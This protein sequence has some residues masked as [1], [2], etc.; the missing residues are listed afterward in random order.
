MKLVSRWWPPRGHRVGRFWQCRMWV[1]TIVWWILLKTGSLFQ[2][3]TKFNSGPGLLTAY[4]FQMEEPASPLTSFHIFLGFQSSSLCHLQRHVF[5]SAK[6]K[7]AIVFSLI[8]KR[9]IW[10]AVTWN[11]T[12]PGRV[13]L[14]DLFCWL[15]ACV[16]LFH[17]SQVFGSNTCLTLK[18]YTEPESLPAKDEAAAIRQPSTVRRWMLFTN[19]RLDVTFPLQ[20]RWITAVPVLHAILN[21]CSEIRRVWKEVQEALR[22]FWLALP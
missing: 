8:I 1:G 18:I 9:G 14:P 10:A 15:L 19:S 3:F 5:L 4:L 6:I 17:T 12:C 16:F 11:L 20:R 22:V 2:V 21:L 7:S 13:R